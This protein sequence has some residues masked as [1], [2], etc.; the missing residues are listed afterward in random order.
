M[1]N[2]SKTLL[3]LFSAILFFG[4]EDEEK[5]PFP[6]SALT[7]GAVLRTISYSSPAIVNKNDVA[8]SDIVIELEADDFQNNTRFASMDVYVSFADR[9]FD[10]DGTTDTTLDDEDISAGEELLLSVPAS[11][12]TAAENGKPRYTLTVNAQDVVDLLGLGPN[13]DRLDGG[14]IFRTRVAMILED[15]SVFTSSNVGDN[16]TGQ[17]FASP[18][19]YE[20]DVVCILATPPTGEWT[21]AG[22]DSYGDGWNGASITVNI[23]GESALEF[24]VD[25]D[26]NTE[27]FT[28][29]ADAQSLNFVY[30]A[31]SFDGEVSFQIT[32][33]SGN[34][35]ADVVPSPSAGEINLNL[36]QE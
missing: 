14:D 4:C 28:V 34:V 2:S 29:P 1:K 13:L 17:F 36:C 33:P 20:A 6:R 8:G 22:Q 3:F 27:S 12:F 35:V 32:A 9:F 21:I 7:Q 23:D 31:G 18:F 16:V 10:K 24:V 5:N 25:V 26:E 30:N 15:G 19:R 11:E